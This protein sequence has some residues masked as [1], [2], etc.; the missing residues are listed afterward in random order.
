M[1]YL[2]RHLDININRINNPT[3]SSEKKPDTLQTHKHDY[4]CFPFLWCERRLP[5]IQHLAKLVEN[6]LEEKKPTYNRTKALQVITQNPDC[7]LT[8]TSEQK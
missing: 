4:T 8:M 3:A 7:D 5:R 6:C 1:H 2:D